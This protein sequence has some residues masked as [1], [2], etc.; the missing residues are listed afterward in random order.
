MNGLSAFDTAGTPGPPILL[1]DDEAAILDGLR[2]QLRRTFTVHTAT[3]GAEA[4]RLL[5]SEQITVVV[6]DMRMP[7]MDGAT[8][9]SHVRRHDPHIVR[10]LLTGN[11]DAESAIAAVNQGQI[12]RFLTKPCPPE[13][14]AAELGRAVELHRIATAEKELLRTTL[15]GTVEALTATLSLAQ[16]ALLAR[17]VRINRIVSELVEAL[18]VEE[19]WEIEVTSMLAHLGAVTLPPTV[20]AKLEAGRP[21]DEDEQEMESRVIGLSR[22]LVAAIPRLERVADGI[23]WQR[24]RYDG[25]GKRPG[26]PGGEDLPLGARI[27]RVA[28]DF[29]AGMTVRRSVQDTIAVLQADSGAYDPQVFEALIRC[30]AVEDVPSPPRPVDV[31]ELQEGME[32]FDDI[33]TTSGVLLVGRGTVV[34]EALIH[35]LENYAGRGEVTRVIR[36][37]G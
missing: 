27:L 14:L 20:L 22:D 30:H 2:R 15:F 9:L 4:L 29:D 5:E 21:L 13:V 25:K 10:I 33:A 7:E 28:V 31:Y 8:F 35:R 19:P 3:N 6:S 16:P 11:A 23:G 26:V 12:S 24:A 37:K 36:V 32:V 17:A 1:V 18:E 34:T